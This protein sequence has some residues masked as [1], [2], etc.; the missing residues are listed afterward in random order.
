[1]QIIQDEVRLQG[2]L[3]VTV[4]NVI[5]SMRMISSVDWAKFFESVSLVDVE[6]RAES[7]FAAMDFPSRDLYR[8]S[9]EML[10]RGSNLTELDVTKR[11]I[12]AAHKAAQTMRTG[13][14]SDR[15]RDP[16]YYLIA[17]GRRRF[18]REL[19]Y[20]HPASEWLRSFNSAAGCAGFLVLL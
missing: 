8:R 7:E 10:A 16:G 15:E 12:E 14:L 5:T 17:R 20:R 18:E 2:A 13:S 11:A 9:I 1:D 4:R 3:N 19:G 6:L